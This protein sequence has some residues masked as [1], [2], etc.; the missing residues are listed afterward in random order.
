MERS[1]R[2]IEAAA[3]SI[4]TKQGY[5]GTSIREIADKAGF[6]VGNI[7]NHYPTKEDLF[8]TLVR[9]YEERIG[10]LRAAAFEQLNDV[11]EHSELERLAISV[12]DIVYKHPDYWRLMYIDV[13]EFGNKHFAH[14]Y[15]GWSEQVEAILGER[16]RASAKRGPWGGLKPSLTFTIIYLQFFTYYLVET[17]FNAKRHLGVSDEEAI[18]QMITMMTQGIWVKRRGKAAT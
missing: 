10:E 18:Q 11:F 15:Q 13:V 12:R 5:H 3:L 8:I 6:S 1:R 2:K 9:R 4:F 14:V 16:L 7:Y 17:L